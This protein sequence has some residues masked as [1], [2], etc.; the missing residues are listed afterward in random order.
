MQWPFPSGNHT[1]YPISQAQQPGMNPFKMIFT[2][3]NH[4]N[5]NDKDDYDNDDDDGDVDNHSGA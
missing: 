5:N 3:F 4:D 1:G 2:F